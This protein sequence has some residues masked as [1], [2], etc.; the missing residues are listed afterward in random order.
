MR[1]P[2]G[3]EVMNRSRGQ[4]GLA[5]PGC[6]SEVTSY[7]SDSLRVQEERPPSFCGCGLDPLNAAEAPA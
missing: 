7:G 1:L 3:G 4:E 2:G 5:Q 6:G